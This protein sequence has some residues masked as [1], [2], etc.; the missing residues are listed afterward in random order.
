M[1]F[2]NGLTMARI[3]L[4]PAFLAVL[5]SD[6]PN[7]RWLSV[8]FFLLA[9]GTDW[10]DGYLARRRQ[11]ITNFGKL[12]DPLADKLLI[13]SALIAL[14]QTGDLHAWV[15]IVIIGRE[16]FVTGLR[17]LAAT[18]GSIMAAGMLGK[19]KT[20]SQTVAVAWTLAQW[21][22]ND[23]WMY[24]ALFFTLWSGLDYFFK[25]WKM[26]DINLK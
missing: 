5:F 8:L 15:V 23:Y 1:N 19:I 10:L 20:I 18:K 17:G 14:V 2:S 22:Y 7:A 16:F 11:E 26:G 3:V 13:S 21:A 24:A 9:A 12:M 6:M 4:I 25:A